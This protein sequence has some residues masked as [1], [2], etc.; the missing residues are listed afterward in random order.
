MPLV[1][2]YFPPAFLFFA[3]AAGVLGHPTP[4]IPVRAFFDQGGSARIQV[5][6]D[7][8]LFAEKPAEELYLQSWTL[9]ET[10]QEEK[11]KLMAQA[12]SYIQKAVEFRF[13]PLG[14]INPEFVFTFTTLGGGPFKKID[15]PLVLT[16]EWKTTVPSGIQGYRIKARPEGGFSV[17]FVNTLMG[18]KVERFQTLFPGEE[19]F[20]L[21]LS[22]IGLGAVPGRMEDSVGAT[23]TS[24]DWVAT[25]VGEMR[26]GFVHV[27]PLGWDHMLFVLGLFLLSRKW[28]PLLLQ[29]TT[30]TVAHTITLGLATL[31]HISV[32]ASIV[33]PIIAASIVF[34]AL[35]NI[36]HPKYTHWRLGVVFFFG[37]IHGLGFAGVLIEEKLAPATL[38]VGLV[39][40]NIGVEGGQIAVILIAFALTCWIRDAAKYRRYI[41]IPG[42]LAIAL[43]GIWWTI[44]RV[45]L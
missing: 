38:V 1:F 22:G 33:E 6:I 31:G 11:Q 28:K 27:L 3:F 13:E 19:S 26:R 2:R 32:P 21:D 17:L 30:F 18:K 7:L 29:V 37:L 14:S 44:Q 9:E 41:V 42:S 5:E 45:F 34:V 15:D 16:G 40:F 12:A 39:G 43:M 35:E 4:D 20:V 10:S 24:R 8:R 23:A 25:F 36:F